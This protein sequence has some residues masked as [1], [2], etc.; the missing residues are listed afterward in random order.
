MQRFSDERFI[1]QGGKHERTDLQ[2]FSAAANPPTAGSRVQAPRGNP[3][4]AAAPLAP[5]GIFKGG[6][7][8]FPLKRV[9][10]ILFCT[11][12]KVWSAAAR[13]IEA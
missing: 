1:Q 8:A 12:R 4:G 6:N 7:C 10:C 3:K 11:S 13:R 2:K 5:R 9:F